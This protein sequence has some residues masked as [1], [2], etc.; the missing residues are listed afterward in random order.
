[1]KPALETDRLLLRRFTLEDVDVLLEIFSDPETMRYYSATKTREETVKW[2]EWSLQSYD[3]HGFALWAVIRKDTGQF[4]GQCGLILQRDVD[5]KDEV[6]I[7]YSFL[8]RQWNQGF[9]TEA[10]RACRDFGF[11]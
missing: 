9:A 6:E 1:M 11:I 8:R 4:V 3:E 7:G 2:I 10:A 5:G